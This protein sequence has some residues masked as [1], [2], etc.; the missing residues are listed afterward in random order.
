MFSSV[1]RGSYPLWRERV[2]RSSLADVAGEAPEGELEKIAN[3]AV[4]LG[5]WDARAALEGVAMAR[6]HTTGPQRQFLRKLLERKCG[7]TYDE[8]SRLEK[9]ALAPPVSQTPSRPLPRLG[10]ARPASESANPALGAPQELAAPTRKLPKLGLQ[11][12]PPEAIVVEEQKPVDTSLPLPPAGDE[13]L[14]PKRALPRLGTPK[15]PPAPE[16]PPK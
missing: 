6:L 16:E 15:R 9:D 1:T 12:P 3:H 4:T 7:L 10:V 11:A 14:T 5:Y 13:S 8:L 2:S